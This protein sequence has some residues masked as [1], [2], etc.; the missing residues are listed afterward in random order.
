V[1]ENLF[2]KISIFEIESEKNHFLAR[3]NLDKLQFRKYVK[4]LA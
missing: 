3:A 1:P 2:F 4:D